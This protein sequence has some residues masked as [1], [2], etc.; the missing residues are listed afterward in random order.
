MHNNGDNAVASN[1]KMSRTTDYIKSLEDFE[2]AFLK[3]FKLRTYLKPT[4]ELILKEIKNRRLQDSELDNI[5]QKLEFNSSNTG[6]PRCNSK[7][8][9]NEVID[10]GMN[11]GHSGIGMVYTA[12]A[13]SNGI[14]LQA[15]GE[16]IICEICGY[17][18]K[19]DDDTIT[20]W[21]RINSGIKN[22]KKRK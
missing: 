7:K 4:Q 6:C 21:D 2:L 8:I 16:K 10:A 17:I 12:V 15:Q 5:V 13:S 22:I 18:L 14:D 19:N 1:W 20:L 9:R 3:K 11:S